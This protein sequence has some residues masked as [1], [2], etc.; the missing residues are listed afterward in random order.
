MGVTKSSATTII[1]SQSIGA[2]ASYTSSGHDVTA[3]VAAGVDVFLD[4]SSSPS[5]GSVTIEVLG[6]QDGTNFSDEALYT[7]VT[8]PSGDRR[9]V[10]QFNCIG[11]KYVALK[12]SNGTN[13][14][15]TATASIIT[16]M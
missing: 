9:V 8:T 6:S 14:S 11:V 16:A 10:F 3:A 4:Y 15:L 2:S 13:Q 5:S 12:I 1:N 7:A